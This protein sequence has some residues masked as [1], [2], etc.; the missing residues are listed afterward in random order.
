MKNIFMIL[1]LILVSCAPPAKDGSAGPQGLRG[2]TGVSGNDGHSIVFTTTPA[3]LDQ[4]PTGG[5]TMMLAIDTNDNS[6]LDIND[7]NIQS[8]T[9]CNGLVGDIGPQGSNAPPTAFTPTAI[10]TPCGANSSPYKEVLLF[11]ANC[12][13][14]ASFSDN[15]SGH[16]TRFALISDGNFVDTDDSDCVFNVSTSA[17]SR[18]VSW[19]AGHNDYATW[20]VGSQTCQLAH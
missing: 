20:G 1:L 17:T 9:T 16:H 4:C 8:L 18:T 14:L 19:N 10:V 7:G 15:P 3:S 5:T 2:E 13:L 12:D 6:V 11:L